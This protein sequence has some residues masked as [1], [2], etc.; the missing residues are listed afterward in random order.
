MK[1]IILCADDYSQNPAINQ[2]ILTLAKKKRLSAISCM[3]NSPTWAE[4]AKALKE[5]N[6][7]DLGVHLNFT[8]GVPLSDELKARYQHFPTSMATIVMTVISG[9]LNHDNIYAEMLCQLEAFE[10]ATGHPPHFID[11]HQHIHHFPIFRTALIKA[12]LARYIEHKPYIR[13]SGNQLLEKHFT[14]KKSIIY[15][16]GAN[17]LR[18]KIQQ[19]HIPHNQYFTGVYNFKP[20]YAEHFKQFSQDIPQGSL[21]MCHPGKHSED[22]DDPIAKARADEFN[23]FNSNIFPELLSRFKLRLNRFKDIPSFHHTI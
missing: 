3:T 7:C 6:H 10:R 13:V 12:Y 14:L 17:S 19:H 8:H 4:D 5:L 9:S 16:T 22:S 20:N 21:I 11:G 2:G 15:L 1:K 23:F 18:K